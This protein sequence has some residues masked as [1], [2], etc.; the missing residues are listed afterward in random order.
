MWIPGILVSEARKRI[1]FV[2][3]VIIYVPIDNF[4]NR[5]EKGGGR[6]HLLC[7]VVSASTHKLCCKGG[8]L[9]PCNHE[10]RGVLWHQKHHETTSAGNGAKAS[11]I[12]NF[13]RNAGPNS[14]CECLKIWDPKISTDNHVD[15]KITTI[16]WNCILFQNPVPR[17]SWT[18]HPWPNCL[19]HLFLWDPR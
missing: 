7:Q 18:I 5:S 9:N 11:R 15:R 8:T 3:G 16:H 19:V 4:V 10:I 14:K 13:T 6:T 2:W 1:H 17:V 12:R